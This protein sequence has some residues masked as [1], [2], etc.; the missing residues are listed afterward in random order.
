MS[1]RLRARAWGA[2]AAWI[3]FVVA[4]ASVV[5]TY[6]APMWAGIAL[7]AVGI[8]V[9]GVALSASALSARAS[10]SS[11]AVLPHG[12]GDVLS[13]ALADIDAQTRQVRADNAHLVTAPPPAEPVDLETPPDSARPS[14]AQ[15]QVAAAPRPPRVPPA[16]P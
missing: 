15:A 3:A 10:S 1:P 12:P 5:G 8:V 9:A 6:G 7:V 16:V 2:F 13:A 4:A 11:A 14:Q